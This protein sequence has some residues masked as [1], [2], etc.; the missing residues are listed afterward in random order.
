MHNTYSTKLFPNLKQYFEN[1]RIIENSIYLLFYFR[2]SSYS[3]PSKMYNINGMIKYFRQ[4]I[5]KLLTYF[6]FGIVMIWQ[7][8]TNFK[9]AIIIHIFK[10][11]VKN[12]VTNQRPISL[13]C[14]LAI[15]LEEI[16]RPINIFRA[17]Y[18]IY[19]CFSLCSW[20]R[21]LLIRT[22]SNDPVNLLFVWV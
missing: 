7:P 22:V 3:S 9:V 14:C 2:I 12:D 6:E 16:V 13:I 5:L 8:A 21:A 4:W 10:S 1:Y 17:I 19:F 11:G 20:T 15:V 18:T